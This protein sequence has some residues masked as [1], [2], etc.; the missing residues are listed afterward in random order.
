MN[1]YSY[2][3]YGE[4]TKDVHVSSIILSPK[5]YGKIVSEINSNYALYRNERFCMHYSL[6]NFGRYCI[7]IFI[8]YGYNEYVFV[9]KRKF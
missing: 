1:S 8:N 6:D 4:E 7:Y 2:N 5:E 9:G 3:D